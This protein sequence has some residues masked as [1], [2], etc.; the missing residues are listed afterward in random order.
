[1]LKNTIIIVKDSWWLL[2]LFSVTD[3]TAKLNGLNTELQGENKIIA[4]M[5]GATDSLRGK[6]K[7]WKN[8]LKE[9]VLTHFPSVQ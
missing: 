4:E 6:L 9:G 3:L 8:Q 1:M 5:I 7:L 2:D